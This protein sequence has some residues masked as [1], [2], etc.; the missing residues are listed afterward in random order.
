MLLKLNVLT[1]M[2]EAGFVKTLPLFRE[3]HDAK[4]IMFV[5]VPLKR[6]FRISDSCLIIEF[7][8]Y[9]DTIPT[10][11]SHTVIEYCHLSAA[12]TALSRHWLYYFHD[13][14][15]MSS[16]YG[17]RDRCSKPPKNNL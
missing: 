11:F 12:K 10:F 9:L 8:P 5:K 16:D 3:L 6:K 7:A 13:V 4:K 15:K 14:L 2:L 17:R 1:Q